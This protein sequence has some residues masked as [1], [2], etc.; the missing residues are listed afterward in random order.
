[1]IRAPDPAFWRLLEAFFGTSLLLYLLRIYARLHPTRRLNSSDYVISLAVV[2]EIIATSLLVAAIT[3]GLGRH[4]YYVTLE[5]HVDISRLLFGDN[6]LGTW[7]SCLAR[8]SVALMLL[9]FDISALWRTVL[10]V[11]IGFQLA[12]AFS[13]N[14][15]ILVR[16]HP[17]RAMWDVVPDAKCWTS[18]QINLAFYIFAGIVMICDLAF[19]IMPMFLV[20]KLNRPLLERILISVLMALGLCATATVAVKVYLSTISDTI[21]V[22][23]YRETLRVCLWCRLEEYLLIASACAPCL[24][25]LIEGFLRRLGVKFTYLTRDL[26]SFQFSTDVP[27]Q[28]YSAEQSEGDKY[29]ETE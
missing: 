9:R 26:N 17:I 12:I 19:A 18:Q 5:K 28:Q 13:S 20:W 24:K 27:H 4:N 1:V 3:E 22:D 11:T 15:T 7:V 10:W 8:I 25:P 6:L 23:T 2:I 29:T 21:L 14:V 16:C